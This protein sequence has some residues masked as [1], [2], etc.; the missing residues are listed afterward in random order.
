MLAADYGE[1]KKRGNQPSKDRRFFARGG[2]LL[3]L[4]L[5]R[6]K[7]RHELEKPIRD[8]LLN[9]QSRWNS[10]SKVLQPDSS[11]SGEI[12]FDTIG[13]LPLAH[14]EV[15]DLLAEDWG[16]IL[17]LKGLPDD[18]VPDPLMRLSGLA[19]I[20]YI[21]RRSTEILKL[22]PPVFPLD[23]VSSET[24]A[25]QKLAKDSFR[26][27][28]DQSR[29]AIK[30]VVDDLVD[31]EEWR[32]ALGKHDPLKA[33][34]DLVERRFGYEDPE[35]PISR[36]PDEIKE[37]AISDHDQHLGRVAG[38]YAEQIGMAVTK[39]GHGRW[40]A[41][42]DS[43][44]EAL[45]LANVTTPME[46]EI[47]LEKLW[48]RYRIVVGTEVSRK[49]F[50]SVN[51]AHLKANQRILEERLRILGLVKRLSDDCAFVINPF[52]E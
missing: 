17:S 26:R 45:V 30:Q 44:L 13:Y 2:E 3:F 15:Y 39:R 12:L 6:S 1:P 27:H 24:V 5:N 10:L 41:A 47:F 32:Q 40:Y 29:A 38:F 49:A 25:V 31:S 18:N 33:V 11:A 37:E 4:M 14:H 16:A 34:K 42:S 48:D 19:V 51:Y 35:G 36:I 22:E 7:L 21:T 8:R 52:W 46:F 20:Q 28:R 50:Q 9:R 23:M 43:L